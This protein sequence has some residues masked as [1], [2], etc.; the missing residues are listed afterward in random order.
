MEMTLALVLALGIASTSVVM[1]RQH[2]TFIRFVSEF[3]FLRDEA[4]LINMLLARLLPRATSYRIYPST[5]SAIAESGAINSGGSAVLLRNRNPDGTFQL[6]V[7]AFETI[8]GETGLNL[9][10]HDGNDWPDEP[11]WTIS[12]KPTSVT[13]SNDTGVLLVTVVGPSGE[14]IT[15]VGGAE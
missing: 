13:F 10:N 7:V 3:D 12:S 15:Y 9:Y 14:E 4:P 6:S 11:D 1:M 5:E 8:D 2:I